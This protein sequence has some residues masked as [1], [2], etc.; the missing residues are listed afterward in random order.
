[1]AKEVCVF[2]EG[3]PKTI[4]ELRTTQCMEL[5]MK[6]GHMRNDHY[7]SGLLLARVL[8]EPAADTLRCS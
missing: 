2:E 8:E 5:K 4:F 1:M 3:S 7:V 6:H